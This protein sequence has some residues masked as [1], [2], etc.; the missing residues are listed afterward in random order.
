MSFPG[1]TNGKEPGYQ[2]RRHK[3]C[4]FDPSVKKI[5]WRRAWQPTPY[6]CLENP[7][8]REA[9]QATACAQS[10]T[11]LKWF[12]MHVQIYILISLVTQSCL[13]LWDPRD[14][15]TLGFP[16]L[17]HL[18]EFTQTHVRW[19][20]DAIQPSHPL[21]PPSPPALNLSQ[22]QGLFPWAGSL[23]HVAKVLELQLQHQS[24][25]WMFRVDMRR[26][27]K[28]LTTIRLGNTSFTWCLWRVLRK[29][30][31]Q[32]WYRQWCD[33]KNTPG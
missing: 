5:P 13:T 21:L 14:C 19:V 8:D 33:G 9:W 27:C 23:H 17:H 10:W 29:E 32:E 4:K 24:F 26:Y 18:P 2:C 28:T 6:S 7:M 31:L 20:G 3:R 16:V 1:G 22:H 12:S 30:V 11:Q 15:G 25:Q